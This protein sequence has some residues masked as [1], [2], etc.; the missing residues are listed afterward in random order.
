MMPF[1]QHLKSVF[2]SSSN[3]VEFSLGKM[4]SLDVSTQAEPER[5]AG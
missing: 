3:D 2:T 5:A 4:Y 1:S